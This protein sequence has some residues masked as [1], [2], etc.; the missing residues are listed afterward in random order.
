MSNHVGNEGQLKIG[1]NAVGELRGFDITEE[2]GTVDDTVMGDDWETHKTNHKKWSGSANVL[3]DEADTTGQGA[4]TVGASVTLN[5]YPEGSTSGDT[6]LTGTA[7]V[8]KRTITST[9]NGLVEMAIEY[10]G[11]GPLT[12]TTVGA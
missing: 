3:W 11:N 8:T 4:C 9:H 2:I 6:Y 7:T 5:G 10:L 12:T 1:A